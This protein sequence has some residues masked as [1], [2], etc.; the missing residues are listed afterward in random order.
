M[1]FLVKKTA[2]FGR[3]FGR[4]D[5]FGQLAENNSLKRTLRVYYATFC[6][7]TKFQLSRS[8]RF[9]VIGD[10]VE[11]SQ[12]EISSNFGPFFRALS[13]RKSKK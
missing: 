5:D 9:R 2:D 3:F 4:A 13:V 1:N 10:F 7:K 8:S 11:K 12:I 6:Q